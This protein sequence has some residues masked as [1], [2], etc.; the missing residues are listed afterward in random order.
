ME[1]RVVEQF[2]KLWKKQSKNGVIKM[3][4]DDW[5]AGLIAGEGSFTVYCINDDD[6]FGEEHDYIYE[7]G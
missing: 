3:M 1:K 7:E 2:R 5:I 6:E 4:S